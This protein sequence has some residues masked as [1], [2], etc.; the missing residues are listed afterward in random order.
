VAHALPGYGRAVSPRARVVLVVGVV[1]AAAAAVAIAGGLRGSGT[2]ERPAAH[3]SG[4][5]PLALDLGLRNDARTRALA[6]AERLYTRGRVARAAAIFRRYDVLSARIGAAFAAWPDGTVAQ[7]RALVSAHPRS[8]EARL[9]HGLA[10]YWSSRLDGA[11]AAWR[12]AVR[13]EPDSLSAVRAGD[14]LHPDS[15]RGLPTFVPSF[16]PPAAIVRLPPAQQL[17]VLARGA[18]AGGVRDRLLYGIA[19]QR[20]GRPV[21]AERAYAG[22]AALA[23]HDVEALVAAA[24]GRFRKDRPERAFSRLGPLARRHP[25]S[26]TVRFHLGLLL[27]WLGEIPDARRQLELAYAAGPGSPLGREAKRFLERLESNGTG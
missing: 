15:P 7:L 16:A 5:P 9:H 27:L 23:P 10:L 21:S 19:L 6:S 11:T 20:V 18:R 14:L 1:A 26:P 17:A 24:V 8:A 13:V 2:E 25:S 3:R 4:R 12:A 22:A